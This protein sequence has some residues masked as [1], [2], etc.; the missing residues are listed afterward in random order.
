MKNKFISF[1]IAAG[2]TTIIIFLFFSGIS[3]TLEY[4]SLD[5]LFKMRGERK[6]DKKVVIVDIDDISL[7]YLGKWPWPRDVH[8]RIIKYLNELGVKG[9]GFDVLFTEKDPNTSSQLA[10]SRA[11]KRAKNVYHAMFFNLIPRDKQSLKIKYEEETPFNKRVLDKNSFKG[12]I[13][14]KC[15]CFWMANKVTLP[16]GFLGYFAKGIGYVNAEPDVDGVRRRAPVFIEYKNKLY[17]PFA[18]KMILDY[19]GI[20][21][22]DIKIYPGKYILIENKGIKIPINKKGEVLLNFPSGFEKF[23]RISYADIFYTKYFEHID[24]EK[25]KPFYNYVRDTLSVSKY[26]TKYISKASSGVKEIKLVMDSKIKPVRIIDRKK[27][28]RLLKG[29]LVLIGAS[30]TAM[31]DLYPIP[32]APQFPQVGIWATF[33]DNFLKNKFIYPLNPLVFL[34][35]I[36]GFSLSVVFISVNLKPFK[37]FVF[38]MLILGIYVI[39]AKL[40][41]LKF[42]Y[43]LPLV[44]PF[45]NIFGIY[46]T[47]TTYRFTTEEREKRRIRN[48]FSRYVSSQVVEVILKN[49][50]KIS[51]VGER[52]KVTIFFSDIRGF[53]SFS[54]KIQPEEV[55][56]ILNEYLNK[57]TDI[58]FS[59]QGT[60][61]KFI[62][63]AIMAIWGAP[64]YFEDHAEKAVSAAIKMKKEIDV[65]MDKWK[66]EGRSFKGVGMG[67]NTGEVVVGNLG[68]DKFVDYTAIGDEVNLSARLEEMAKPGQ[69]LVSENTFNIVKD[70]FEFN[71]IGGVKVKGKE[72]EVIVYEVK[73]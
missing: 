29:N 72:K 48:M 20:K 23:K 10:L 56:K 63:D 27:L 28:E 17:F 5:I 7:E 41:F 59:Y 13:L 36:L 58:I 4:K 50:E 15:R 35:V 33:M 67:I 16:S 34:L 39:L 2:V 22:N 25:Q 6:A 51:L 40:F 47:V 71:R 65:L 73:L 49:P 19:L 42:N 30:A 70:R 66:K 3:K 46:I 61:D 53:T 44:H 38:I 21:D 54:E 18:S 60:L 68:S 52:R 43:W 55:V 12:E 14:S 11:T 45:L 24:E 32:I 62:G 64:Y 26:K 69:I 31:T 57:M 1:I 9:I 8:A 37:G